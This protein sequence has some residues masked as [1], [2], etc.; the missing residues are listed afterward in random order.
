MGKK[1]KAEKKENFDL[2]PSLTIGST[3]KLTVALPNGE[4]ATVTPKGKWQ[5]KY[6]LR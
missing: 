3:G 6:D 2:T 1:P 4:T 5:K